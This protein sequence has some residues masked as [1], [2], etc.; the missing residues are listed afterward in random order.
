MSGVTQ[1]TLQMVRRH[2]Q[3]T[4]AWPNSYVRARTILNPHDFMNACRLAPNRIQ[5]LY[6]GIPSSVLLNV[7]AHHLRIAMA[8]LNNRAEFIVYLCDFMTHSPDRALNTLGRSKEFRDA[9]RKAAEKER[10]K[11]WKRPMT[12]RLDIELG[13]R[14]QRR[15]D[16]S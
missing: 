2:L 16:P 14:W 6:T 15:L 3:P 11:N 9:R 8:D 1:I 10:K 12:A 7:V 4:Q 13:P 5:E